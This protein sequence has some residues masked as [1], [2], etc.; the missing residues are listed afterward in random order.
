MIKRDL[1]DPLV[2]L[3]LYVSRIQL[4]LITVKVLTP[5]GEFANMCVLP[6]VVT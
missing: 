5:C 2:L 3:L 1:Y 4:S 6:E